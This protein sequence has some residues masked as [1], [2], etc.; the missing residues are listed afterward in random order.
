MKPL[1]KIA[2]ECPIKEDIVISGISGRFPE[3]DNMDEFAQKLFSGEDMVTKDDRR[4][5]VEINDGLG[6]R[7][8]KLKSLDKFDSSFFSM[9]TYLSH[10]MDPVSRI[11]LE[12]TYEAFHDA[13]V[14]PH[15]I[16]GSNT[17]VYFGI[18]TIGK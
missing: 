6:S 1:S 7:T 18:N 17:G 5:P 15:Q 11:V 10:S 8:G 3:S 12:T 2:N 9:L 14:C 4:W 13:G 16:R